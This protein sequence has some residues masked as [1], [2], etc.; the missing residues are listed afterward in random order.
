MTTLAASPP[1][2]V[3][4]LL[5]VEEALCVPAAGVDDVAADDALLAEEAVAQEALLAAAVVRARRGVAH[6]Q[7][8]LGVAVFLG[9]KNRFYHHLQSRHHL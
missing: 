8:V 5:V 4:V 2:P 9:R 1:V 3:S 7:T 6:A